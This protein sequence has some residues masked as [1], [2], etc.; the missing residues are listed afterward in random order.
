MAQV[1][2]YMFCDLFLPL[3]ETRAISVTDEE[4]KVW[5]VYFVHLPEGI[6]QLRKD[7]KPDLSAPASFH[8]VLPPTQA[9]VQSFQITVNPDSS[10]VNYSPLLFVC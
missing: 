4:S 7:A 6:H 2:S 1:I 3:R 5:V 8:F 9:L 10:Q